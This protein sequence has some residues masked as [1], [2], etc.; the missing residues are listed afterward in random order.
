MHTVTGKERE[1]VTSME[2]VR[3][4]SRIVRGARGQ[5]NGGTAGELECGV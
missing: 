2:Q 3:R 5:E 1:T 4:C